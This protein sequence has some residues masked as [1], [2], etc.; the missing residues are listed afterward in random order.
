[1]TKASYV[2]LGPFRGILGDFGGIPG[3]FRGFLADFRGVWQ[4]FSVVS[5]GLRCVM[6]SKLV[7][8]GFDIAF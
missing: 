6:W 2:D 4:A 1:M 8:V 5:K 7:L 3:S